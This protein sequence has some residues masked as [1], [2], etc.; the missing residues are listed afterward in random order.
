MNKTLKL[1]QTEA[2]LLKVSEQLQYGLLGALGMAIV[3]IC[4]PVLPSQ[5]GT[6]QGHGLAMIADFLGETRTLSS[7]P[8][9]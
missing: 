4:D 8:F 1:P 7:L 9:L 3:I 5:L 6:F 2:W